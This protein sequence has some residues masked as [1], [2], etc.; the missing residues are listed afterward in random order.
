MSIELVR[1]QQL[2]ALRGFVAVGRLQSITQA[3]EQLC[4]TQ[5]AVSRQIAALEQRLGTALFARGHRSIRFTAAGARLFQQLDPAFEQIQS[6][7]GELL[8]PAQ[9]RPVTITASIGMAALWLLPRLARF[10][11]AHPDIDVRVAASDKV[12]DLR[13]DGI[14]LALRYCADSAVPP[15]SVRLFSETLLPVAAGSLA[16][17][18]G[19]SELLDGAVLLEF[20]APQRPWLHWAH[21]LQQRG[22]DARRSRSMLRFNQYDQVVQA[23]VQGQGLALGRLALVAPLLADGRLQ[24]LEPLEQGLP[25]DDAYWLIA[26]TGARPAPQR[27]E[28]QTLAAWLRE[29]AA[30]TAALQLPRRKA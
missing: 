14:D 25:L 28:V 9:R 16:Q 3:A 30:A 2:D 8:E 12:L 27:P 26:A 10:Q 18:R 13:A 19:L 23:C 17:G 21:A 29:E 6:A 1:L 20:D 7:L 5:S 24:A 4:L 15:G 11:Q 22:L